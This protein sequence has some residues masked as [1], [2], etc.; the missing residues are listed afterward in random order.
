[1]GKWRRIH[2]GRN[3]PASCGL[4][5]FG[6]YLPC[7]V[8]LSKWHIEIQAAAS[9]CT[10]HPLEKRLNMELIRNVPNAPP[11]VPSCSQSLYFFLLTERNIKVDALR[12]NEL[13]GNPAKNAIQRCQTFP[14]V[15]LRGFVG[16]DANPRTSYHLP[17]EKTGA[18]RRGVF[19]VCSH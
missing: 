3:I 14:L 17:C 8:L 10:R 1:M 16:S 13:L 7:G 5:P 2:S 18:C 9:S 11:R 4:V 6:S 12:W 15:G 19:P